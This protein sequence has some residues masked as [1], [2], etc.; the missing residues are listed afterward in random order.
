MAPSLKFRLLRKATLIVLMPH[1]HALA[2]RSS[3]R[4]QDI[5]GETTIGRRR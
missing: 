5:T 3:I 1:D 2:A 4:P